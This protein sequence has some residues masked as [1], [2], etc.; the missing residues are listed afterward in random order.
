[1]TKLERENQELRRQ[2]AAMTSILAMIRPGTDLIS[3]RTAKA[4]YGETWL[5][6]KLRDAERHGVRLWV[7]TGPA[8]NSPK[9]YSASRLNGI[10]EWERDNGLPYNFKNYKNVE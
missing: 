4:I 2:L 3:Q 8:R 7:R 1:M 9:K 10:L 6:E 5:K